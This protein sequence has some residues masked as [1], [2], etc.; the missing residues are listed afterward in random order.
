MGKIIVKENFDYTISIRPDNCKDCDLWLNNVC[1]AR[2]GS[3]ERLACF[4]ITQSPSKLEN[5]DGIYKGRDSKILLDF[6]KRYNLKAYMTSAIKCVVNRDFNDYQTYRCRPYLIEEISII[7]PK[8]IV[9]VGYHVTKQFLNFRSFNKVINVPHI[10][11]INNEEIVVIP[12]MNYTDVDRK[13]NTQYKESF[14]FIRL[15]YNDVVLNI[16]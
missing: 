16:K 12:I 8:I 4:F 11:N 13:N 5:K 7:R 10:L 3:G 15:V 14:D 1:S 2:G 9:T 6:I